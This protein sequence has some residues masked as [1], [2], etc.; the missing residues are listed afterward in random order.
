VHVACPQILVIISSFPL[1]TSVSTQHERA[2]EV[3]GG[4][5]ARGAAPPASLFIGGRCSPECERA[6]ASGFA[7]VPIAVAHAHNPRVVP[8]VSGSAVESPSRTPTGSDLVTT[9]LG[10]SRGRLDVC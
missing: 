10:E 6:A 7:A 3:A 1:P 9:D 4:R 2:H 5:A 8:S